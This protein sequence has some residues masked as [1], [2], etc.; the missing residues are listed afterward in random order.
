MVKKIIC[1]LI[2]LLIFIPSAHAERRR[3]V[4]VI[5]HRVDVDVSKVGL[6]AEAWKG[7]KP[8][9]HPLQEQFLEVPK[10][11]EVGVKGNLRPVH[12]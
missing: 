8:Y 1:F 12:S 2:C 3:F 11:V 9:R 4:E 6:D 10:P 7:I 5:S